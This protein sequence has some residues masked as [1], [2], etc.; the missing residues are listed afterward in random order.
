MDMTTTSRHLTDLLN[1]VTQPK[2]DKSLT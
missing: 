1:I 2:C